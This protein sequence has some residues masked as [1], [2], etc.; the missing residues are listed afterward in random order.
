MWNR[1]G[2][3]PANESA[4]YPINS[5]ENGVHLRDEQGS[6]VYCYQFDLLQP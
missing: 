2:L 4:L 3:K 5:E 6:D 1:H